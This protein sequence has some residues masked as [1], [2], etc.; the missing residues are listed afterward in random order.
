[1]P[2]FSAPDRPPPP[3]EIVRLSELARSEAETDERASLDEARARVAQ[4]PRD[5]RFRRHLVRGL[6]ASGHFAEAEAEADRFVSAFPVSLDALESAADAKLALRDPAGAAAALAGAVELDP[7]TV[8]RQRRAAVAYVM[9]GDERRAC[10]HFR[11]ASVLAPSDRTLEFEA[12]RCR[13]ATGGGRLELLAELE[14]TGAL[15]PELE[16]LQSALT[17]QRALPSFAPAVVTGFSVQMVCSTRNACP[18]PLLVSEGGDVTAPTR[19]SARAA[20]L[21]I[22][23]PK[24]RMRLYFLGGR[25]PGVS[26]LLSSGE[27]SEQV[28]LTGIEAE[29]SIDLRFSDRSAR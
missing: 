10:A 8:P 20:S 26:A 17:D 12:F 5:A 14:A 9:A 18:V 11:A 29:R 15:T 6:L 27:T 21:H 4:A 23:D 7:L 22:A 28:E 2:R 1:V 16:Q 25:L 19:A 3:F 24:G 13:A